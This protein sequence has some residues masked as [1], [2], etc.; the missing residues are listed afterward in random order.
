MIPL[1]SDSLPPFSTRQMPTD[2]YLA[3]ETD[4][5]R[6]AQQL[7]PCLHPGLLITLEGPLGAGKTMLVR[8]IL[9]TLGVQGQIKSP[10]YALLEM[11]AVSSLYLYHFD[12]YRINSSDELEEAGFRE[13]FSG[14][15]ICFVEW[16]Q[17]AGAWLPVPD[18]AIELDL[19]E[20]KRRL[21]ATPHTP[22]GKLCLDRAF[23]V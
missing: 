11:Y 22:S 6:W 1:F 13:Y 7:A 4:T 9:R 21:V 17:R 10:T 2:W 8:A 18:V 20:E 19:L 16:P 23:P 14:T 15:G 12:F 5:Q 3:N